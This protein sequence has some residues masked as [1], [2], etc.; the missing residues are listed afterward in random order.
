MTYQP[1]RPMWDHQREGFDLSLDAEYFAL[2]MEQRT[3]KTGLT[4]DTACA[5]FESGRINALGILAPSGVHRNWIADEV[6]NCVPERIPHMAIFW[7]AEHHGE[8]MRRA[9]EFAEKERT[10]ARIHDSHAYRAYCDLKT[11]TTFPGLPIIAINIEALRLSETRD[12]LRRFWERRRLFSVVDESTIIKTPGSVQSKLARTLGQHSTMRRILDGTPLAESP[13]DAYAQCRFLG[14]PAELLGTPTYAAFKARYAEYEDQEIWTKTKD[15]PV[16][17]TLP[18]FKCFK[19][20][21][22]LQASLDRFSFRKL[23]RE[24][25]DIPPTLFR[26]RYVELTPKQ[27]TAYTRLRDEFLIDIGGKDVG[28]P[29]VLTRY[30]RLQQILSNFTPVGPG[31]AK[32]CPSCGG[33]GCEVCGGDGFIIPERI[34]RAAPLIDADSEPRMDALIDEINSCKG[35]VVVWSRFVND[36]DRIAATLDKA[37]ITHVRYDGAVDKDQRYLNKT[38]FQNREARVMNADQLA[39]A[40]GVEFSAAERSIYFSNRFSNILRQQSQ[41]R[42]ES[43]KIIMQREVVDLVAEDTIDETIVYSNLSKQRLSEIVMGDA[44]RGLR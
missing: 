25:F 43:G 31:M 39:A 11:L 26:K 5:N 8:A 42:M 20:L 12:F 34:M 44:K 16:Q 33:I 24:C 13:L 4:I 40:R 36:R 14:D 37:G 15:G 32:P 27:R 10:K 21:E 19:N 1:R 41:D 18:T 3:G 23:R 30:L 29:I 2:F 28:V 35:S 38:M 17:R 6:P 22:E 9:R 7:R